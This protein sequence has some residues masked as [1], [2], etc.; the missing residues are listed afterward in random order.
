VYKDRVGL[1]IGDG[2]R[3]GVYE[4]C[5]RAGI[6]FWRVHM[7]IAECF[8][9][10]AHFHRGHVIVFPRENFVVCMQNM[11]FYRVRATRMAAPALITLEIQEQNI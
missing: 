2:N 5:M 9:M 4:V 8:D 1:D 6:W 3:D 7:Y 10:P 11:K